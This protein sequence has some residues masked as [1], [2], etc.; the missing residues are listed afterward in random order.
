MVNHNL[1]ESDDFKAKKA[2]KEL[3]SLRY[4][5]NP[6]LNYLHLQRHVIAYS[7]IDFRMQDEKYNILDLGCGDG[8]ISRVLSSK[9]PV[10]GLDVSKEMLIKARNIAKDERVNFVLGDIF[11]IPLKKGSVDIIMCMSVL[12]HMLDLHNA[13]K[14]IKTVLRDGGILIVGYPIETKVFKKLVKYFWPDVY[15]TIDSEIK[16]IEE[17]NKSPFTH[18]QNYKAIR[19]ILNRNFTIVKKEKLLFKGAPDLFC[20]Y[21]VVKMEK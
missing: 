4:T 9:V 3:R 18:K 19:K 1:F 14:I 5:K 16:G 21:E 10:I 11:N 15:W 17:Y 8:H 6:I 13:I 12:E 7:F 2:I 20:Y